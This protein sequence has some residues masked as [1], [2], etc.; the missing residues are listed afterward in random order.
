MDYKSTLVLDLY[1]HP[2]SDT[3]R[4]NVLHFTPKNDNFT[5]TLANNSAKPTPLEVH[6]P[7]QTQISLLGPHPSH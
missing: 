1:S 6:I 3:Y 5:L 2:Q 7:S 4:L